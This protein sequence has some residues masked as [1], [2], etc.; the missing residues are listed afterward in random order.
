MIME[1]MQ[2]MKEEFIDESLLQD[3]S[4]NLPNQQTNFLPE[5]SYR[6]VFYV[7]LYT[8]IY[9]FIKQRDRQEIQKDP[10]NFK[11]LM[12]GPD[13]VPKYIWFQ[14]LFEFPQY[15]LVLYGMY[16]SIQ[17]GSVEDKSTTAIYIYIYIPFAYLYI[18]KRKYILFAI[19]GRIEI[20]AQ[21][22]ILAFILNRLVQA[23]RISI[24]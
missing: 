24:K 10:Q 3:L 6:A 23:G 13:C 19:L 5:A 16:N 21:I 4:T 17:F 15:M 14:D 11:P 2:I 18:Y 22:F 1:Q 12:R 20:Q 9:V 8:Y 7:S